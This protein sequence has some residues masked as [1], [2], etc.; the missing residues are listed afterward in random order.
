VASR[1]TPRASPIHHPPAARARDVL[2]FFD[3]DQKARAPFDAHRLMERLDLAAGWPAPGSTE[4]M[5]A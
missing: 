1:T 5:S 3:N 2:V 4:G